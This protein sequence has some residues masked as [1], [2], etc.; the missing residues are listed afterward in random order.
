ME[1]VKTVTGRW[2]VSQD[3]SFRQLVIARDAEITAPQGKRVT[4]TVGGVV[5]NMAPGRYSGDIRFSV[6]D[7]IPVEFFMGDP[8]HLTAAVCVEDGEYRA[9]KSVAAA[10]VGGDV[11]GGIHGVSVEDKSDGFNALLVKGGGEYE[12]D[13]A[14]VNLEGDGGNDFCGFAAGIC[15]LDD[16]KLTVKNS[17]VTV[18]GVARPAVFTGGHTVTR[19]ENV[20]VRA[21]NGVL[22]A[23]YRDSIMPGEMKCVPWMLG[24]RGNCRATNLADY[25]IAY[26]DNCQVYSEGWG[27]LSTDGV[28]LCRLHVKDTHVEITGPSGYG[29]F[30]I[31]NCHDYFDSC[32]I[33]VPDYALICANDDAY[34]SFSNGTVVDAGRFAIM[35]FLN[36][37]GA[38]IRDCVLNTGETAFMVKGCAPVIR[39]EN[40]EINAGNGII[41]QLMS[42]DD[43]GN[44]QGYYCDP[45]EDDEA[46]PSHDLTKTEE[47]IDTIAEFCD[48][49]IKGDFYNGF[50]VKKGD[51]GPA[52]EMP[53]PPPMPE[54]EDGPEGGPGHF[55][56]PYE[57]ARNLCLTFRNSTVEGVISAAKAVH[58]VPKISQENCE[59]LGEVVNTPREAI[60]NGVNVTLDGASV[61]VVTGT[62]Y[63]TSLNLKRGAR[64]T[65]PEGRTVTMTVDG[66]ETPIGKSGNYAGHITISVK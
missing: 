15:A 47:H 48:M 13:G 49:N 5:R 46:D 52:M 44:P 33:K 30:A 19:L 61:W 34:G 57:G 41:L 6:T 66:V 9:E 51:T 38:D 4:M 58:R 35:F 20:V 22:P 17:Q 39:V 32:T 29:A 23:E 21:Y 16:V 40:T 42:S 64:V 24:L 11:D 18:R 45:T 25:G 65:A 1:K 43:P 28:D 50:A 7:D 60:N 8:L 14:V 63:I 53:A 36:K 12:I 26:W 59:E 55:E 54:G 62:S 56:P 3:V 2:E 31:G 27:V 37:G 10:A